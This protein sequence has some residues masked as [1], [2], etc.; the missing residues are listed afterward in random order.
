[1]T[2]SGF[3]DR[4]DAGWRLARLLEGYRDRDP[5][6]LGMARGGLPVAAE[7]AR[8]LGARL[9]VLV[10][11]KV[12]APSQPELALG[13][14]AEGIERIDEPL[15]R[16]LGV[17]R[18]EVDRIVAR[19][20]AE[21]ARR[22]AAYRG[23]RVG[24]ELTG[25]FVIVV[26][27]G[28]ATGMSALAALDSVRSRRPAGLVFAVP[29]ASIAGRERVA[30]GCDDFVAVLVPDDFRSVGE[31]Y[32]DFRATSDGEV[33]EALAEADRH[34][35][36]GG[37]RPALTGQRIVVPI[38]GGR[39]DGLL[40]VPPAARGLVLFAHGSGSSR[41]S[42]RNA[43]VAGEL[44][45]AGFA[46]LQFDLLT[47]AESAD[48]RNVFDIELLADRLIRAIDWAGREPA[49]AGLPVGLFGASTGAAAALVAAA[50][51]VE[52]VGACVSRG[53]RPDLAGE[54]LA[55]VRAPTLLIVGGSDQPVVDLNRTAL[56]RLAGVAA[57]EVVPGA[58]HLF[59]EPGRL[60]EVARLAAAWF[61]RYLGSGPPGQ[62][63]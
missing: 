52:A 6:V 56:A 23:G 58:T 45:A 34:R 25:R 36:A 31:W 27:D 54:A 18:A 38:E 29:V 32:D 50:A 33:I 19:E 47:E 7:V 43:F 61:G 41:L 37:G 24:V 4:A 20:R 5:I 14:I 13:A 39:L 63:R 53:G 8:H 48:R 59:E 28:L 22:E 62:V 42:P 44:Q 57:L 3:V 51:R 1:M 60:A 15:A 17:S 11:R 16:R 55:G 26:D 21:L 46:T 40:T 10:V 12:G 49:V 9:D 35:E 30:P 2:R